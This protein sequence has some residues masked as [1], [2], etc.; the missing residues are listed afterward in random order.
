[1]DH[2]EVAIELKDV[3]KTFARASGPTLA[4]MDLAVRRGSIHVLLGHSGTGKSVTLKHMLG[5]IEPDRG[6]IRIAGEP[7]DSADEVRLREIRR[8]FGMLFQSSALFD[9][10]SVFDNVAF[11]LREHRPEWGE[12]RIAARVEELLGLVEL[13]DIGEE[14]PSDLSGGMRKRVGLARAIALEPDILLF[15]EPTTGLDPVTSH[16]IDDLIVKTT[17]DLGATSFIISHDIH[18]A[19]R[20]ADVISFLWQGKILES[21]SPD[22]F[23]RSSSDP[24][25]RI[26]RSAGVNE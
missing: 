13:P 21:G 19:L 4:G 20:I 7:L 1:M 15:D 16:V 10:L 23:R 2:P 11:P 18:A 24:I 17:R 22:E 6:E 14:M 9:S 3:W 12:E 26:L 8:H 5:L 25:R